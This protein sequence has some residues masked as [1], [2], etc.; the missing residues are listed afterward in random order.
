MG[1]ELEV[2]VKFTE[3]KT[4]KVLRSLL[5]V[6]VSAVLAELVIYGNGILNIDMAGGK[7]IL[8][9]G[10]AAVVL[11]AFNALNPSYPDY[12]VGTIKK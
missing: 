6:F 4:Y 11:T 12:G 3:T 8:A 9:A 2:K 7:A 5:K 1:E 10:L